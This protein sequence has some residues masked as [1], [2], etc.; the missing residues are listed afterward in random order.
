LTTCHPKGS[1]R[2]RLIIRAQLVES[3]PH[4]PG[5]ETTTG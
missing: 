5:G 3:V 1:A 4:D 2:E